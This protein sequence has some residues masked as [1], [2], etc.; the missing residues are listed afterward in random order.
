MDLCVMRSC[1]LSYCKTVNAVTVGVYYVNSMLKISNL[2]VLCQ[3]F[4]DE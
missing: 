4:V 1:M 3:T 2:I